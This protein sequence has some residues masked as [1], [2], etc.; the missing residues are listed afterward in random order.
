IFSELDSKV[1]NFT[2]IKGIHY[3]GKQKTKAG[4]RSDSGRNE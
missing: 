2:A 4:S 1:T 3:G